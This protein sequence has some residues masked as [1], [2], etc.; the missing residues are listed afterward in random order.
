MRMQKVFSEAS[1]LTP[2][3]SI[4][5]CASYIAQ[6][7]F[8]ARAQIGSAESRLVPRVSKSKKL[9]FIV[10]SIAAAGLCCGSDSSANTNNPA[11]TGACGPLPPPSWPNFK[12]QFDKFVMGLCYQKQDWP[13]EANRR[14]SEG[15][16]APYV[17]LWYSPQ[18]YRWMTLR[19]RQG[20]IPDGSVVIKEEYP[21]TNPSS[22]ILFWSGMIKDAGLW[23][24]GW[25]WAVVGTEVTGSAT[26]A[27]TTTFSAT[28]SGGCAEPQ[29]SFNG[30]TSINCIGCHASAISGSSSNSGQ[31]WSR[32]LLHPTI[33]DPCDRRER[34]SDA[35][36][37]LS[38][39][40]NASPFQ[41]IMGIHRPAAGVGNRKYEDAPRFVDRDTV[42]GARVEGFSG[43]EAF[44]QES[45]F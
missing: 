15:L 13:H 31:P 18:L 36:L 45:S 35:S 5:A 17:K 44:L 3:A 16:H 7:F 10:L 37:L 25:Y 34:E 33:R 21:D 8:G 12:D 19:N 20:P 1:S 38:A 28:T 43:L 26:A 32:N 27:S 9:L 11:F 30:P 23:W 40:R 22:A 6:K 29:F 4:A 39:D 42:Y 14:S 2:K 24:D 41:S